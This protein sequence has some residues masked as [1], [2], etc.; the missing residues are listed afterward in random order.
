MR[1][2]LKK[3]IKNYNKRLEDKGI[4]RR[5]YFLTDLQHSILKPISES[6]KKI[7]S[8]TIIGIEISEDYKKIEIITGEKINEFNNFLG[9]K[10]C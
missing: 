8:D 3:A 7:D 6:I 2:S 5:L 1:E 9:K 4:K 10:K